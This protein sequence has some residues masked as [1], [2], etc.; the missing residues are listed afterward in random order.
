MVVVKEF[1]LEESYEKFL[2]DLIAQIVKLRIEEGLSQKELA[3]RMGVKPI[4]VK[5][6]EDMEGNLNLEFVY[7]LLKA[8]DAE[9]IIRR[10]DCVEGRVSEREEIL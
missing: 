1:S 10:V 7:K 4:S 8:L 6:F 9:L 3:L 5:K 2:M